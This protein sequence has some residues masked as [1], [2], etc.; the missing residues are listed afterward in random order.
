MNVL[1]FGLS[2]IEQI[3]TLANGDDSIFE[4]LYFGSLR[5]KSF[6]MSG[7]DIAFQLL[8]CRLGR[9]NELRGSRLVCL[10]MNNT[11]ELFAFRT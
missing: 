5:T 2:P 8:E 10:E 4:D 1:L 3:V 9:S 6:D 7:I 11:K